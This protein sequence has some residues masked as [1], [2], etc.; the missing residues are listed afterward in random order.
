M[1]ISPLET[2]KVVEELRRQD[3]ISDPNIE[4]N[5]DERP[6][7]DSSELQDVSATKGAIQQICQLLAIRLKDS[8]QLSVDKPLNVEVYSLHFPYIQYM[9]KFTGISQ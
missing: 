3:L 5:P 8:D 2:L 6:T 9:S 1:G 4:F 7:A